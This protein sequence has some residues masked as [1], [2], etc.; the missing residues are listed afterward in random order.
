MTTTLEQKPATLGF[1][2][3]IEI[4]R[5]ADLLTGAFEGGSNYWYQIEEFVKPKNLNNS[6]EGQQT[7]ET[8]FK[9]IDYPINEGG[10]LIISDINEEDDDKETWTLNLESLTKGLQVMAKDYPN[11]M[12]NF[13]AFND[14]AETS[15]V[16][17]QCCL[18]GEVI[19][20]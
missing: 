1:T 2:Q 7:F 17:L 6:E 5:I 16:Y 4:Q 19:F 3:E 10:A 13:L 15:D 14:D 18:F 9:H 20:G 8:C 12:A 11:H